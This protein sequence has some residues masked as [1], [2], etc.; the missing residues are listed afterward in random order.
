VIYTGKTET[1][2]GGF[3]LALWEGRPD[4]I[5]TGREELGFP[6]LFADIPDVRL[7]PAS[8]R[9]A[10]QASWMDFRFFELEMH[11]FEEVQPTERVLLGARG[12]P[13]FYK[14][15][16]RTGPF[17]SGG[18]DAAYATTSAAPP[19]ASGAAT[20][21][22]FGDADYRKWKAAGGSVRWHRASFEQLPTICHVVNG[23]ADLDILEVVSTEMIE[24]SAPGVAVATNRHRAVEA[25]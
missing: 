18:C 24:F 13:I 23:I 20:T 14:Y 8:G 10:G 7:D 21:I 17:G 3:C 4:A 16:P 9:I 1:I 19:G 12:A 5:T 6:K 2:E 25:T 15:M 22:Q 11:G